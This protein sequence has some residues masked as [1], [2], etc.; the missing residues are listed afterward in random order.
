MSGVDAARAP[1][2]NV[3]AADASK[4]TSSGGGAYAW[5][6]GRNEAGEVG[7]RPHEEGALFLHEP[8]QDDQG[9]EA[10]G[11]GSGDGNSSSSG[12]GGRGGGA[13]GV[14]VGGCVRRLRERVTPKGLAH[15]ATCSSAVSYCLSER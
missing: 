4:E 11:G 15:H 14:G 13:G 8:F 2:A 7:G 12:G 1:M 5:R 9:T 6:E 3:G 10:G